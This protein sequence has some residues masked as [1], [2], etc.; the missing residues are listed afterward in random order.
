MRGSSPSQP[1]ESSSIHASSHFAAGPPLLRLAIAYFAI[2]IIWGSTYLALRW[3]LD[4][5]PPLFTMGI[6]HLTAGIILLGFM[7]WRGYRPKLGAWWQAAVTG[8]ILFLG[9]HGLLAWAELHVATG[10]CSL[11]I[12]SE[13]LLM[14]LLAS[15]MGQEK[16]VSGRTYGG[17]A[18]GMVGIALLFGVGQGENSRLGLFAVMV[19]ALLWTVGA[20]VGRGMKHGCHVAVFA[21]MQMLCGGALLLLVGTFTGERLHPAEVALHSWLG[22]GY[23]ILFGSIFAFSSYQWLLQVQS[24]ARVAMHC[25]VNPVVAVFLGWFFAGEAVTAR[26]LTGATIILLSVALVSL[27]GGATETPAEPLVEA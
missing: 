23:M 27:P 24:A 5:I 7:A 22:L 9:G 8:G 1:S 16:R 10:L 12:A 11:I 25:Y 18:V 4:G 13:P 3:A 21:A 6:R 26:M 19:S 14:V 17:L 20:I 2:Y 15:L